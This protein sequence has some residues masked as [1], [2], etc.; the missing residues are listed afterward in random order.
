[1]MEPLAREGFGVMAVSLRCHGD[2][3]GTSH[4]VGYSARHDV[5]AA[6]EVIERQ[7][8]GG[9]IIICGSSFGAAAAAYASGE[10]GDRVHGYLFD[11]LYGDLRTALWNRLDHRLPCGVRHMAYGS[12]RVWAPVFL[13]VAVDALRPAD[14]VARI[15]PTI[16]IV[17]AVGSEDFRSPPRE[18]RAMYDTVRSHAELVEFAG[19]GH[20]LLN[21]SDPARYATTLR[22]RLP[23]Q[24]SRHQHDHGNT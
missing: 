4:D 22:G 15:S 6:V 24:S 5:I 7:R 21:V 11:S 14:H 16:P 17:I 12:L 2:S 20:S 3:T 1:V 23:P 10:L 8:P 9:R 19:A 13:P 18:A